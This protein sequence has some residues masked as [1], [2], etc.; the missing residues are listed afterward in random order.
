MIAKEYELLATKLDVI[1][2]LLAFMITNDRTT[3]EQIEMLLKAG[4][5][6]SDI[7]DILGKTQNQIYVAKNKLKNKR[8]IDDKDGD[9]F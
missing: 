1:S 5:K 8:Q 3:S 6:T 9:K 4:L 2:R 7:S